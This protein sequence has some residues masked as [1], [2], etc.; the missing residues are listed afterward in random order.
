LPTEAEWEYAC[1]AGATT[2]WNNGDDEDNVGEVVANLGISY[3]SPEGFKRQARR[4]APKTNGMGYLTLA[5]GGRFQANAWGLHDMHGNVW[6][7]CGDYYAADYYKGSPPED[8]R[9]PTEGE[10]RVVRG[11]SWSGTPAQ[12]RSANRFG[13]NPLSASLW[14]GFRVACDSGG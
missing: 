11:G 6:Q 1:R 2:R 10:L 8:P 12:C 14:L 7:W 4:N 3:S 5:P 13:L 9:G